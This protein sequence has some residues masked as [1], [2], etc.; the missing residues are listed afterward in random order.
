MRTGTVGRQWSRR[1]PV[2]GLITGRAAVVTLVLLL[3]LLLCVRGDPGAHGARDPVTAPPTPPHHAWRVGAHR[4][5]LTSPPPSPPVPH[6]A[7]LAPHTGRTILIIPIN[8]TLTPPS[9]LADFLACT[10][11]AHVPS[12]AGRAFDVGLAVYGEGGGPRLAEEEGL[13][14]MTARAVAAAAASKPHSLQ[15]RHQPTVMV[16]RGG[17][18]G[19]SSSLDDMLAAA[20][21]SGRTAGGGVRCAAWARELAAPP[22]PPSQYTHAVVLEPDVCALRVGWLDIA[23]APLLHDPALQAVHFGGARVRCVRDP[24]HRFRACLEEG[25]GAAAA[26]AAMAPP[27]Q[28][29]GPLC[30][31]GAYRLGAS[32][33]VPALGRA[34]AGPG[35][36]GRPWHA[37]GPTTRMEKRGGT[38]PPPLP[39]PQAHA[40]LVRV[41]APVDVDLFADAAYYGADAR[42]ALVHAPRHWRVPGPHAV[43]ARL[44]RPA[45]LILLPSPP[46]PGL[47]DLVRVLWRSLHEAG[48]HRTGIAFVAQSRQGFDAA[49][50]VAAQ[51]VLLVRPGRGG[52]GGGGGVDEDG[53]GGPLSFARNC[54]EAGM[55]SPS[56]LFSSSL[57]P[58]PPLGPTQGA[59]AP[60]RASA[61]AAMAAVSDLV[62]AGATSMLVVGADTAVTGSF[63]SGLRSLERLSSDGDTPTIF[64]GCGR[65]HGGDAGL[66]ATAPPGQPWRPTE[67]GLVDYG[68]LFMTT[69]GAP[70]ALADALGAWF[71]ATSGRVNADRHQGEDDAGRG[72][73]SPR[74][75]TTPQGPSLPADLCALPGPA[76]VMPLPRRGGARGHQA[77][78]PGEWSGAHS[79]EAPSGSSPSPPLITPSLGFACVPAIPGIAT[80]P[81]NPH[82]TP[83]DWAGAS[84]S[85]LRCAS[86]HA[87]AAVVRPDPCFRHALLRRRHIRVRLDDGGASVWRALRVVTAFLAFVR[88]AR[89]DCAVLPG[90][91]LDGGSMSWRGGGGPR[92]HHTFVPFDA[93]LNVTTLQALSGGRA[94]FYGRHADM[95]GPPPVDGLTP[96]DVW[97]AV[98]RHGRHGRPPAALPAHLVT[99]WFEEW[100]A[101]ARGGG[102]GQG[103]Q[104]WGCTSHF[105]KLCELR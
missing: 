20:F 18:H 79:R 52:G 49:S 74:E 58:P 65:H 89:V 21:T 13:L 87:V 98:G 10:L 4:H 26:A 91:V 63:I 104:G 40:R 86:P 29:S 12:V 67:T 105:T 47:H 9:H 36:P 43:A 22:P 5:P 41:E 82:P 62:R 46:T 102:G 15:G 93:V 94:V 1:L 16:L 73:A 72:R 85:R 75:A 24:V 81:T 53:E 51:A 99:P 71:N 83:R 6:P 92:H 32:T 95:G 97:A 38:G 33:M 19:R 70:S 100:A 37:S 88:E 96:F 66:L 64:A 27:S 78:P 55:P 76:L 77:P 80:C 59:L 60:A 28:Q 61:T 48:A 11:G 39:P 3:L 69:T 35:A 25:A 44:G 31:S 14:D 84:L 50:A 17:H 8:A 2:S 7:I 90:F 30:I 57:S 68:A 103:L 23:L 45:T 101:K 54:V 42:A 56:S 34:E